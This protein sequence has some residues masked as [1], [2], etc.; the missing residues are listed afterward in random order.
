MPNEITISNSLTYASGVVKASKTDQ[1]IRVD[2]TTLSYD[3]GIQE[4]AASY[5][6]LDLADV[7]SPGWA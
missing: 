1:T 3:S 5:E 7:V 2:Q 6:A 4:V